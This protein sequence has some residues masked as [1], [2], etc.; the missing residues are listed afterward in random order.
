MF[1]KR[2]LV[3]VAGLLAF[4]DAKAQ[5]PEFSQFYAA[6]LYLNPAFAGTAGGP[7]FNLNY[8][9]QWPGINNAYEHF[10][11]SY[12]QH[13]PTLGGGIGVLVTSDDQA[14]G[15]FKNTH[16]GAMYSYLLKVNKEVT[17]KAGIHTTYANHSVNGNN[18]I[19]AYDNGGNPIYSSNPNG[20]RSISF[21][22]FGAGA[23]IFTEKVFGGVSVDH[24]TEPNHSIDG[25]NVPLARKYTGHVGMFI[26]VNKRKKNPASISPNVLYQQQGASQQLNLGM[27][28]NQGPIVIGGWY[29]TT[30]VNGDALIAL[31]GVKYEMLKV[32]YSYDIVTSKLRTSASGAHEVSLS[33]ELPAPDRRVRGKS[34]KRINCPSF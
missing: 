5:D 28:Y 25:G 15:V 3:V 30:L 17:I 19:Y 24:L 12:D 31:V 23:L 26:P 21:V 20:N 34:Y 10:A 16:V 2:I 18:L 9:N 32:G 7:R 13:I 4:M 6:P 22:D 29:R 1:Y 14:N 27:Y 8:R 33:V 11:F